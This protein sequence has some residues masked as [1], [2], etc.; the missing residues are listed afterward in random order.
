MY[1]ESEQRAQFFNRL[2]GVSRLDTPTLAEIKADD[3]ATGTA[4]GVIILVAAAG[5][6]ATGAPI[7]TLLGYIVARIAWFIAGALL[8]YSLGTTVFRVKETDA[9]W[10][11]IFRTLGFAQFPAV[12]QALGIIPGM[13][14]TVYISIFVVANLWRFAAMTAAV[15]YVLSFES[16]VRAVAM[17][18]IAFVPWLAIEIF[19]QPPD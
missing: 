14:P 16:N 17:V 7:P 13:G 5:W 12:V 2:V 1:R 4:I 15:R 10:V 3:R 9:T 8:V 19:L 11:Q 18:G 6:F